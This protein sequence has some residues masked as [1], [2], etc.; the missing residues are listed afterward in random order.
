MP[1]YKSPISRISW[2][3]VLLVIVVLVPCIVPSHTRPTC[4][5]SFESV[6]GRTTLLLHGNALSKA[7]LSVPKGALEPLGL[8]V[9]LPGRLHTSEKA[10]LSLQ[11]LWFDHCHLTLLWRP[12]QE[13]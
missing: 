5:P 9:H 13:S 2:R 4:A 12:M 10:T 11:L 8:L 6:P 1:F 7:S 3:L